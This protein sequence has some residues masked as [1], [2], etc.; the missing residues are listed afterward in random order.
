V[1]GKDDVVVIPQGAIL[2]TPNGQFPM[3][4]SVRYEAA[5]LLCDAS[6]QPVQCSTKLSQHTTGVGQIAGSVNNQRL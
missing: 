2:S 3:S 6:S 1:L 5:H 4:V